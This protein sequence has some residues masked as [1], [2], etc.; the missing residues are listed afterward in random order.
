MALLR[1]IFSIFVKCVNPNLFNAALMI[2]L[3]KFELLKFNIYLFKQHIRMCNNKS[4]KDLNCKL[5][6]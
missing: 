2:T 6:N 4:L 3:C 1:L 5:K